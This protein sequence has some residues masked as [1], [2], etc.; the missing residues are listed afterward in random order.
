MMR[1]E[2]DFLYEVGPDALEFIQTEASVSV[3]PFLRNFVYGVIFNS[4]RAAFLDPQV[5]QALNYAVDR[6]KLVE[7]AFKGHGRTANGPAWPLHWAYDESVPGYSYDPARAAALLDAAGMSVSRGNGDN[8]G[9]PARLRFTC[10]LPANFALWERMGLLVQRN[11]FELGVDMRIEEVPFDVLN[12]RIADGNFDAVFIELIAGN[13]PTRPYFF[14]HS[15]SGRNSWGYGN[16]DVDGALDG[17]RHARDENSYR[18]AFR[19]F[20]R[21]MIEI[22]PSSWHLVSRAVVSRRLDRLLGRDIA[23]SIA[24]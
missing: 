9:A 15:A 13:S 22:P 16:Q 7:Q 24:D 8:E 17:I 10:L 6:V 2:I 18:D 3:F 11:L 23:P 5:R 14:W 19:R 12:Q 1:G 21:G 4:K 20:Q